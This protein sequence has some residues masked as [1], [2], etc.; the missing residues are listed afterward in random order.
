M[1]GINASLI[2]LR[3]GDTYLVCRCS[4]DAAA[5]AADC[6]R[7][8]LTA[9]ACTSA[10]WANSDRNCMF[11][12]A[13]CK[14]CCRAASYAFCKMTRAV[15]KYCTVYCTIACLQAVEVS[16]HHKELHLNLRQQGSVCCKAIYESFE[17]FPIDVNFEAHCSFRIPL[18]RNKVCINY[19]FSFTH[20]VGQDIL[21][22]L[23]ELGLPD[24][25][26]WVNLHTSVC[27]SGGTAVILRILYIC[28]ASLPQESRIQ[29]CC[30]RELVSS[31]CSRT[32][33]AG[34]AF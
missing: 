13:H 10:A 31:L 4:F 22:M 1:Q 26:L 17:H 6:E 21:Q 25:V 24:I 27:A 34:A 15:F 9:C 7:A 16:I 29:N 5:S 12:K 30:C 2:L 28:I 20:F 3:I 8:R 11:S 14:P 32:V 23:Q 33:T 18:T 19:H